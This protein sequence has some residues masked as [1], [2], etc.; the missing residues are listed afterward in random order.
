[1]NEG[2]N[3]EEI[4]AS[5]AQTNNIA[6]NLKHIEDN[7]LEK[8]IDVIATNLKIFADVGENRPTTNISRRSLRETVSG[9]DAGFSYQTQA[10]QPQPAVTPVD[11]L[12]FIAVV[13]IILWL[14][15]QVLETH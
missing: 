4:D 7:D 6:A 12:A 11:F 9:R 3:K 2:P 15:T 5:E 10:P 14:L 8:Q 1:M 13:V